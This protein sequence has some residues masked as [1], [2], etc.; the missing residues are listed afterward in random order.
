VAGRADNQGSSSRQRILQAARHLFARRG[1]E[2]TS[3]A[4]IARMAHSSESQLLKHFGSKVGL[5]EAIF[6][7][8]W[9]NINPALRLA[10]ESVPSVREKFRIL[11]DMV[12]TFLAKDE[13]LKRLFLFEGRRIRHDGESVILV[14]G[15]LEFVGIMD[16]ILGEL[17]KEGDLPPN[18]RPQ[19]VRSAVMGAV[20]GMLRD[21]LLA[22]YVHYPADFSENE[23]RAI[24]LRLL[25][26]TVVRPR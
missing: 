4:A 10:T 3:T 12:L 14:P 22:Q 7:Q 8:A 6:Q 21:R 19:A 11:V 23:M 9:G 20:E 15:F 16:G 24:V 2:A 13:E 25:G 5:L 18:I 1:Y 26:S 17:A